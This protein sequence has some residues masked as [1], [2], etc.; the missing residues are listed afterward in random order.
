MHVLPHRSPCLGGC[1]IH[2][3]FHIE[4]Y[5]LPRM[6]EGIGNYWSACLAGA[7]WRKSYE[8]AVTRIW[9]KLSCFLVSPRGKS[10]PAGRSNT[11]P[12]NQFGHGILF[13]MKFVPGPWIL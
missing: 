7:R 6:F 3:A 2:F 13:F 12:K 8:V 10:H 5:Q 1:R 4:H 11:A 9:N